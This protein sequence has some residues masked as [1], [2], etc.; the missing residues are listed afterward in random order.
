MKLKYISWTIFLI[1]IAYVISFYGDLPDKVAAHFDLDGNPNRYDGKSV[2]IVMLFIELFVLG[3]FE[4]VSNMDPNAMNH[5]VKLTEE[6]KAFQI[7]NTLATLHGIGVFVAIL[8]LSI[9]RYM[10]QK[11][12]NTHYPMIMVNIVLVAMFV[13][14]GWR[15]YLSFRHQ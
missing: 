5:P 4:V 15:I 12:I 8:M 7:K 2:F 9:V 1:T 11:T 14:I 6:N 10:H 3:L 13:F